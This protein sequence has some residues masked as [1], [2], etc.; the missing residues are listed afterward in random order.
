MG[1]PKGR[2]DELTFDVPSLA[3]VS[4]QRAPFYL[5]DWTDAWNYRVLPATA[6]VFFANVLVS[7]IFKQGERTGRL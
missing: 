5:S 3:L 7:N 6:F 2:K 1:E 4:L